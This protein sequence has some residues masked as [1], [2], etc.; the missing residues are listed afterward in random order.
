M[1]KIFLILV[2][3]V[4]AGAFNLSY[5]QI[6][7]ITETDSKIKKTYENYIEKFVN[8]VTL[9]RYDIDSGEVDSE[10]EKISKTFVD[11][12]KNTLTDISYYPNYSKTVVA[13][14][15]SKNISDVSIYYSDNSLMS[16]VITKYE[17]DGNVKHKIYY[18]GNSMTFKTINSYSSGNLVRQD[19]VDS[20]GKNL[21][22]S[23]L[24]FYNSNMLIEED[25]F[26]QADSLEIVFQ[27]SYDNAG[28]C[29]EENVNYPGASYTSKIVNKYDDRGNKTESV[30]YGIGDKIT[31]RSE[32]KYDDK[33]LMTEE[34]TFS[35]DNKP[36][37][38]NEYKYDEYGKKTEWKSYDFKEDL[39]YLYKIIYDEK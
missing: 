7:L 38:K 27:Y 16:R 39:E 34:S 2:L 14:N 23:K 1:R 35:I 6:K 10:S 24:Y 5:S 15:D 26:N 36:V 33:S 25:K 3:I 32:Y 28:N 20:L 37:T 17:T 13:F 29:I 21:S 11:L 30:M 31:S 18:F 4:T 22:Y 19:Y 8:T 9:Y 12:N